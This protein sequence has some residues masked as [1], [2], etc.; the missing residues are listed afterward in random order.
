MKFRRSTALP[1]ASVVALSI[2]TSAAF[3]EP[4]KPAAPTAKPVVAATQ[5]PAKPQTK[6]P[7]NTVPTLPPPTVPTAPHKPKAA[8]AKTTTTGA[9]RPQNSNVRRSVAGGPTLDEANLG[10][11]TPELRA[12]RSAEEELFRTAM[13]ELGKPWPSDLPTP[14]TRTLRVDTRLPGA[15]PKSKPTLKTQKPVDV[16]KLSMPDLPVQ[17]DAR[18]VKYLEFFKDDPRGRGVLSLWLRRAGRYRDYVQA[19]L[20]RKGLPEDLFYLAMIESGF[21]PV[22]RSPVGAAGLWQFMPETGRIYGLAQDRWVDGRMNVEL[23]TEAAADYL[24]DLYR[25]FGSW[26]LA[27][28]SYN[29]GYGGM[30]GSIKRYN[31]N[32]FWT[33]SRVESGLPWETTLYVPKILAIAVIARNPEAFG[34]SN[35]TA[36]AAFVADEVLTPPGTA[37]SSLAKCAGAS[38]KDLGDLNPEIRSGRTPPTGDYPVRV[39]AGKGASCQ[40]VLPKTHPPSG[41]K[42]TLKLGETLDGVAETHKTSAERI[43]EM[44]AIGPSETLRA[45]TV[46]FVPEV[47]AQAQ[48]AAIGRLEAK[49]TGTKTHVVLSGT[50]A[51]YPN[52]KRVFYRVLTGDVVADIASTFGVASE[53]L[54]RW[55]SID[56]RARL[57]EGMV[58]QVF[59]PRPQDAE[60]AACLEEKEV[61]IL[62]PGTQEFFE[63]TDEKGR[64][65]RVVKAKAG[66]TLGSIGRE[67]NVTASLMER[68]NRKGRNDAL[69][70]G[71]DVVAYV[72]DPKKKPGPKPPISRDARNWPAKSARTS[73]RV[74]DKQTPP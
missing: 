1:L 17:W 49:V 34:Y 53:D 36:D 5:A 38:T 14:S 73:E 51:T 24:A 60:R 2:V 58:L 57:V 48:G 41:A 3:A 52:R 68:I 15:S 16:S 31:S 9:T 42:H 13:P 67:L 8:A 72:V 40:E 55:N 45:G 10:P 12:L 69:R 64:T 39:P 50:N 62:R 4:G 27:M 66:Q 6:P 28:A 56:P 71:E 65:R 23:A 63:K 20:R 54:V 29:M 43:A 11:D 74:E 18:V 59:S 35:I 19:V 21:E 44:N 37:L 25:R 22:A 26:E 30:M 7:A 61:S 47:Q 46:L 32:D 70:P 33:L